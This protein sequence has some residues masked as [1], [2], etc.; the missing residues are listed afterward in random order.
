M[1]PD[2]TSVRVPNAIIM[3][4]VER[5]EHF[6]RIYT[7]HYAAVLGYCVRR[8]DRS[9]AQDVTS[10]VFTVAWRRLDIVPT[11]D[12]TRPW[13]FGVASR[14]L[15]NHRRSERRRVNLGTKLRGLARRDAAPAETQ[16]IRRVEDQRMLDAI[17]RL[18]DSD[19]ELLL[20]S[21]WEGLPASQLALRFDVSLKAAEK[22]LTRA[23]KRL[24]GELQRT[25]ARSIA[26]D[27]PQ[28]QEGGSR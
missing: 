25:E 10:E 24:A 14:T 11:G 13:L 22:R 15:A 3:D 9:H 6:K 28:T 5:T 1:H 19:R 7:E 17:N 8:V 12:G 26:M 2:I 27:A 20:L 21:A 23:K 16:V 18:S 4:H